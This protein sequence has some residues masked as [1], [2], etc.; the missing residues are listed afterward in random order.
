MVRSSISKLQVTFSFIFAYLCISKISYNAH[1][2][3]KVIKIIIKRSAIHLYCLRRPGHN[4]TQTQRLQTLCQVL[5][6]HSTLNPTTTCELGF[7]IPLLQVTQPY[8]ELMKTA[9]GHNVS[10]RQS[11]APLPRRPS[12]CSCH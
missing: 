8:R 3:K 10:I 7:Y 9:Q 1:L 12:P 5:D 2:Y 11:S 6:T 4:G